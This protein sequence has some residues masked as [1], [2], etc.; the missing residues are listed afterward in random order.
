MNTEQREFDLNKVY[1]RKAV[2][3]CSSVTISEET[4]AALYIITRVRECRNMIT[5]YIEA[6][7]GRKMSVEQCEEVINATAPIESLAVQ[8]LHDSIDD[9]LND[10]KITQI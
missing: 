1:N 2:N 8:L 9:C 10:A 7:L 4:R 6:I 3:G 5:D